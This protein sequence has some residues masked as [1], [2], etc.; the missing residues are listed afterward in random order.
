MPL[1]E[2]TPKVMEV[3]EACQPEEEGG[4]KVRVIGET[5]EMV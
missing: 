3:A 5:P 1:G 4:V 2:D